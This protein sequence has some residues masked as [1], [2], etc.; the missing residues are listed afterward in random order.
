M[1]KKKKYMN[2]D[3]IKCVDTGKQSSIRTKIIFFHTLA[4]LFL[5]VLYIFFLIKQKQSSDNFFFF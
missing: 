5:L 4:D 1:S 2:L 3:K